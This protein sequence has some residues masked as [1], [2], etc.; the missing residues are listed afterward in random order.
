[1]AR[2]DKFSLFGDYKFGDYKFSLFGN[3]DSNDGAK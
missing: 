3:E 1:M 2:D